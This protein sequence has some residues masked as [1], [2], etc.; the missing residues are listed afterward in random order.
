MCPRQHR[1]SPHWQQTPVLSLLLAPALTQTDHFHSGPAWPQ[2][3]WQGGSPSVCR[4]APWHLWIFLS[5]F[6]LFVESIQKTYNKVIC[7][8]HWYSI[9][10]QQ[11]LSFVTLVK[12]FILPSAQCFSSAVKWDDNGYL[13]GLVWRLNIIHK[14]SQHVCLWYGWVLLMFIL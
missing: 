13:M 1:G 12:L 10:A 9:Q 7:L 3:P 5:R 6:W 8:Q 14:G 11:V 4:V 2:P